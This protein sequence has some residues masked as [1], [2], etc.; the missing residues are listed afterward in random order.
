LHKFPEVVSRLKGVLERFA[1][2]LGCID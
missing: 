1:D 2:A